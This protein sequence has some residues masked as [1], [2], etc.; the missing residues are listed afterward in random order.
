MLCMTKNDLN[1]QIFQ[2]HTY[3]LLIYHFHEV[4]FGE[5]KENIVSS[6][7]RRE[8]EKITKRKEQSKLGLRLHVGGYM[9][10]TEKKA[11][12]F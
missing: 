7:L 11:I 8:R 10:G 12:Y 3:G 6:D 9:V 4:K 1:S 2:F 5:D